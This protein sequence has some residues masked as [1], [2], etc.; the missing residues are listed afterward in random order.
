MNR[1]LLTLSLVLSSTAGT[2]PAFAAYPE[3][4]LRIIVPFSAG[5]PSDSAAR[6]IGKA[7]TTRTGQ[8]TV[9]ENRSGA[10]GSIAAQTVLK[11]TPDGYTLLWSVGS[12][13]AIPL[14][15]KSAPFDSLGRFTPVSIVGR[16]AF[17]MYVHPGVPAKTVEQ[18]IM[19]A[20]GNS[21]QLTFAAATLG[22]YLAAAQFM[23]ASRTT[24]IRV[25][26]KGGTQVMP[27]LLT[28][29][30][31]VYFGPVALGLSYGREGRLRILGIL[32]PQRSPA[33]PDVPTMSEAGMPDVTVPSWQA[34]VAPPNTTPELAKTISRWVNQALEDAD[35]RMQFE[36]LV[37]QSEGSTP[38]RLAGV[39]LRDVEMWRVFI[40]E[41]D[42]PQE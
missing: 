25:P 14:L 39:I 7:L 24:M 3:K 15:Q 28:G 33:A 16:F 9:I 29:R 34:I 8:P 36:R 23:K 40:R 32:L 20:R 10:N 6:V 2:V 38:E 37:L 31:Q 4:P 26:Y 1:G 30:V 12:M 17:G 42:I 18:F 27:D 35:V 22:E 11:A 21:G 13:V 19:Y 5:G 41:Y